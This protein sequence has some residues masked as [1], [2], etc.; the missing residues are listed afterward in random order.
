[1]TP[2]IDRE[3]ISSVKIPVVLSEL[4]G[5][6]LLV[7]L[8]RPDRLNAA[9]PELTRLYMETLL[10]ASSDER[11]RVIVVT[12]AGRSFCAGADTGHLSTLADNVQL[13]PKLRQHWFTT[14][15]PKPI[16]AA[17][18]GPCVGIGF[19]IAM[20]CD[21]RFAAQTA[22]IG[23]AFSRLGLPA[24]SGMAWILPRVIGYARAFEVLTSGRTY[25]G[26]ELL[27]LGLVN[28]VVPAEDLQSHCLRIA[29]EL[30]THCSPRSLAAIKTQLHHGYSTDLRTADKLSEKLLLKFLA[31]GDMKE[32]LRSRKKGLPPHF[33][34]LSINRDEWWPSDEE[35][36]S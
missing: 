18:N 10:A 3:A 35:L 8:N 1:M 13:T 36:P 26:E 6:V 28:E 9:T 34:P 24:E 12:G 4:I 11:V 32:A 21:M 27:R 15:I 22:T 14:E 30:A 20:M 25:V 16:I 7:T 2:P 19:V 29:G 33:K 23:P 5:N 17:I 31:T